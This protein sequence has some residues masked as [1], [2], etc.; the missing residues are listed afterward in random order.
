MKLKTSKQ[1]ETGSLNSVQNLTEGINV[2]LK[3]EKK[4]GRTHQ[5]TGISKNV[6]KRTLLVQ[7]AVARIEKQDRIKL[8]NT[9]PT[10]QTVS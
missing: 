3:T 7:E 4:I 5:N 2:I 10:K 8:K 6:L 9:C 1:R